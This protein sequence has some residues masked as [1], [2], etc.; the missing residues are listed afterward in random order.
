MA[1]GDGNSQNA[2]EDNSTTYED[3]FN[4]GLLG[5]RTRYNTRYEDSYN[6]RYEDNDTDDHH[7][8]RT[9]S[10]AATRTTTRRA[11]T[12]PSESSYETSS[13]YEDNDSFQAELDLESNEVDVWGEDNDVELDS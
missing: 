8:S 4:D 3:S 7:A 11:G 6:S 13:T 1:F 12:G 2:L 5:R 10:T 9:R